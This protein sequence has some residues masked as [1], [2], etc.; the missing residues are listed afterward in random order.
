MG[1]FFYGKLA[2]DNIRKNSRVYVPYIITS[3]STVIMYYLMHSL[4][5]NQS[6]GK[7]AG[8]AQVRSMLSFGFAI[9]GLFSVIF[10]LYTNSFLI[11]RRKKEFGL[12]QVLGMEKKHIARIMIYETAYIAII[13]VLSGLISGII[14][15]RAM[16][17]LLLKILRFEVKL[18]F[19][20][21]SS[22]IVSVL[23]LFAGIYLVTLVWNLWQVHLAKPVDLL[24]G[25]QVGEREPKAKW[26]LTLVGLISIGSGYYIA[27]T[28][29]S[30]IAALVFF[31]VAVMLVMVGTYALFTSGSISFL[32][33][34]RKN[35]RYY[36]TPNHFTSVSGMIYRMK[37]N[38]VG[39][40]NICILSTMVLV[41]ISTTVSL[42]VGIEDVLRTRYPREITISSYGITEAHVV[43]LQRNVSEVLE[44]HEIAPEDTLEYRS[45]VFLGQEED[46]EFL[47]DIEPSSLFAGNPQSLTLVPG[48]DYSRMAGED[49]ALEEAEVLIFSKGGSYKHATLSVL[50]R[51][52]KVKDRLSRFPV[53]SHEASITQSHYVIVRDMSVLEE[54][55]RAQEQSASEYKSELRHF[56]GFDLPQ[57]ADSATIYRAI[58]LALSSGEPFSHV[59]SVDA[60]KDEFYAL[61][62]SLFF[63]GIFLG[64]L[65]VMG[66]VLIIYYKQITE[67]YED[68]G[69]F[70]IMQKVGMGL[71]EVKKSIRSQVVMV[72]FLPLA[73]AVI[74]V[75]AAFRFISKLLAVFNLTNIA[76]FFWC[77]L[78]TALVFALLYALVYA[79]TARVYYRIVTEGQA[80]TQIND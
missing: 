14:L 68:K 42:Y 30:P 1:R 54:L 23:L 60:V 28:T 34:L 74:H 22:S 7:M 49:I 13:S 5:V 58:R 35:K 73:A 41:T 21:S 11:M 77:T 63:L 3:I 8:A 62:G 50:G 10:L 79:I 48:E 52:F 51:T 57:D 67:G 4:A 32:K 64:T 37:K 36:Y 12:V 76:L 56:L 71:E 72:F 69:R 39:L 45:L 17:L 6:L 43:E 44:S 33:L 75:A 20:I 38:A 40:A 26:L 78:G 31:F 55:F 65:F 24:K 80:L 15:S 66:T 46:G 59:E 18:A 47:T 9:V 53:V 16:F 70:E 29:E 25:G 27:L 19:E 2:F 61:Y